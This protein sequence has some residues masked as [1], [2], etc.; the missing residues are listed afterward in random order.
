MVPCRDV[1]SQKPQLK[2]FGYSSGVITMQ[3][4]Y[5]SRKAMV[6]A[7][8]S[9][10]SNN[11]HSSFDVQEYER[12]GKHEHLGVC[13]GRESDGVPSAQH[14]Q[15]LQSVAIVLCMQHIS[16]RFTKNLLR[17]LLCPKIFSCEHR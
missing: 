4:S 13:G 11:L 7:S 10:E 2:A 1:K 17:H 3:E 12:K 9:M 8:P 14:N 16:L 5:T 15:V 6:N